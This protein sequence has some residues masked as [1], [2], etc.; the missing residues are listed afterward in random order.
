MKHSKAVATWVAALAVVLVIALALISQS[1]T[2]LAFLEVGGKLALLVAAIYAAIKANRE[3]KASGLSKEAFQMTKA[4]GPDPLLKQA[5]QV[6]LVMYFLC[7]LP[8]ASFIYAAC[9]GSMAVAFQMLLVITLV[10]APFAGLL[11]WQQNRMRK[12]ANEELIRLRK[13]G[14]S[15]APYQ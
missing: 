14:S 8:I 7:A 3:R 1:R 15:I 4:G 12:I 2:T 11:Y 5:R 13:K 6:R 10:S 9:M